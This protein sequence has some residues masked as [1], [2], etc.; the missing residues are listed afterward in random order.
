VG[1]YLCFYVS[2]SILANGGY[3]IRQ[4]YRLY[5]EWFRW[6]P[7]LTCEF[8]E[9]FEEINFA[10]SRSGFSVLILL[11]GSSRIRVWFTGFFQF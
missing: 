4:L 8:A 3:L 9:V 6:F 5:F 1:F 10:D 2:V 7:G 11:E